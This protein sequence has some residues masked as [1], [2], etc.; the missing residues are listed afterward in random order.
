METTVATG[1]RSPRT[2]GAPPIR[3]GSTVMRSNV[4]RQIY[5]GTGPPTKDRPQSLPVRV[6]VCDRPFDPAARMR[7]A[8]PP[9]E[10]WEPAGLSTNLSTNPSR[11]VLLVMRRSGVRLPKAALFIRSEA[12]FGAPHRPRHD[13][14]RLHR[15][16]R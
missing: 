2:V 13:L 1:I 5:G 10:R 14:L 6:E 3:S 8:R 11:A 15:P 12:L 4:M 7:L 9:D 16:W